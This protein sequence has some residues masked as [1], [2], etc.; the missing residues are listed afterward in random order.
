[1]IRFA[2]AGLFRRLR[3]FL[4]H[5]RWGGQ[6]LICLYISLISGIL[7]TIQYDVRTPYYATA[8]IELVI[9]YGSFWRAL[10]YYSSQA[11]FLLLLAH[12][13]AVLCTRE[14]LPA[15]PGWIRLSASLPIAVLLLFTGYVL[16]A[17]A[18]GEAAGRIAE[19][20]CLSIPVAGAW[21]NDMLFDITRSGIRKPYLHHL[22]GFVA[23]G[24][25]SI[26]PHLRRYPVSW[27][28]H[29]LLILF[30][31]TISALVPAPLEPERFGLLHIAGPW[32]FLG[33]QELLRYLHPFA[34]GVLVPI[35]PVLVLF[36]L[37]K[38]HQYRFWGYALLLLWLLVYAILTWISLA[39]I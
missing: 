3:H 23:L 15:R 33:L 34:A 27:C 24:A 28:Q 20:I 13:T 16:R 4:L 22:I 7:L 9:P 30:L 26:W 11:F 25:F 8:T 18:T 37:P 29:G 10:H 2:A 35:I 31:L 19:N 12:I 32:F 6:T 39:R 14:D 1:M 17:D 36:F 38:Q 5:N 21:L